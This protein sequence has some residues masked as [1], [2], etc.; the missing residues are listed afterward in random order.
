MNLAYGVNRPLEMIDLLPSFLL[1][2][3]QA[4]GDPGIT[5]GHYPLVS[6]QPGGTVDWTSTPEPAVTR[7][8]LQHLL[9]VGFPMTGSSQI[10]A[11][12]EV[13]MT[14]AHVAPGEITEYIRGAR[15]NALETEVDIER[16]IPALLPPQREYTRVFR[17]KHLGRAE[18]LISSDDMVSAYEF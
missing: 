5:T 10:F 14:S 17:V 3:R 1:G 13:A 2:F 7:K 15:L 16:E 6:L 4:N 18:P 11:T 8:W 12:M 9:D